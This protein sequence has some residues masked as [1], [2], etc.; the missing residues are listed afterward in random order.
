V[1]ELQTFL[2]NYVQGPTTY[3]WVWTRRDVSMAGS[4]AWLLAEGTETAATRDIKT[5]HPYRMTIVCEKRDDRWLL[6]HAHGSCP[7]T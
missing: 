4:V 2:D 6:L 5:D 7:H 1:E 3:S